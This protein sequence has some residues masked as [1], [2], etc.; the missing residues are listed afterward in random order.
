MRPRLL[1]AVRRPLQA[2][3]QLEIMYV[4]TKA[5]G[6]GQYNSM[7]IRSTFGT[8]KR[9]RKYSNA[10]S[11]QNMHLRQAVVECTFVD[12]VS[13]C[14]TGLGLCTRTSVRLTSRAQLNY[15]LLG[16][17]VDEPLVT[18]RLA[19]C[20]FGVAIRHF[21]PLSTDEDLQT[22]VLLCG[23]SGHG[24]LRPRLQAFH[25]L[26]R[27]GILALERGGGGLNTLLCLGILA[28]EQG[29]GLNTLLNLRK[30]TFNWGAGGG[31][32]GT[33]GQ[34]TSINPSKSSPCG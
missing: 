8:P 18:L 22:G 32:G 21:A 5:L 11:L 23:W 3:A 24:R 1:H 25:T 17:L 9:R 15:Q 19:G 7:F 30:C 28:F 13:L 26:L 29:G 27:G 31:W 14:I 4:A 34:R 2:V 33:K 6:W 12:E 20:M 16:R 10:K